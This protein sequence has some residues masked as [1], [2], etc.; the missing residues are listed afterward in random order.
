MGMTPEQITLAQKLGLAVLE[1]IQEA[2]ALGAPSGVLYAAMQHH[3]CQLSQYQSLMAPLEQRGYVNL[4]HD[5]Y[6]I[7]GS[8]VG[9][10]TN[11]RRTLASVNAAHSKTTAQ[12][13]T[14]RM[15]ALNLGSI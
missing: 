7:T 13:N 5:C 12:E 6:T 1:S 10:I 2:G 9:L 4:E 8:G 11:L 15:G 14:P 3:G